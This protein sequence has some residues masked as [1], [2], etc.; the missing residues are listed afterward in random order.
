MLGD[1]SR[2][3]HLALP[4]SGGDSVQRSRVSVWW[5]CG[6]LPV[7]L[8][9][10]S[11][12]RP[13]TLSPAIGSVAEG[14][15]LAPPPRLRGGGRSHPWGAWTSA[16]YT[17]APAGRAPWQMLAAQLLPV[18]AQLAGSPL[19]PRH[20]AGPQGAVT[21][22]FLLSPRSLVSDGSPS[23]PA[24]LGKPSKRCWS[25]R[26]SPARSTTACSRTSTARAGAACVGATR[27][28]RSGPAPGSCL[29][30]R[31]PQAGAGLT[32]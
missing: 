27:S 26:R 10:T 20:L 17:W 9:V 8:R 29:G 3:R 22:L 24:Q 32:P 1:L 16:L 31:R 21:P 5:A 12:E 28:P 7:L 13:H 14:C 25:R 23:R 6:Q 11:A 2:A 4:C 18:G 15:G 30:G 19:H